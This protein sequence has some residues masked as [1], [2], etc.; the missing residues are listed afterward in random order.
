[1]TITSMEPED[2]IPSNEELVRFLDDEDDNETI[3]IR[4]LE[5]AAALLNGDISHFSCVDSKLNKCQKYVI[6]YDRR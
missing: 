1:M 4:H 6:T 2:Y 5:Q 3:A